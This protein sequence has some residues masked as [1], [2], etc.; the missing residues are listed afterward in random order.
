VVIKNAK[1]EDGSNN[2]TS[3]NATINT[4]M[5]AM[6]TQKKDLEHLN[7]RKEQYCTSLTAKNKTLIERPA[8]YENR[9]LSYWKDN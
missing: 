9:L 1:E 3:T 5:R 2:S 8:I 6:M 4:N 7:E